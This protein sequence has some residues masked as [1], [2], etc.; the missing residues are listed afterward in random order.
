M[1]AIL[2]DIKAEAQPKFHLNYGLLYSSPRISLLAMYQGP[3]T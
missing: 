2:F 1:Q 3:V